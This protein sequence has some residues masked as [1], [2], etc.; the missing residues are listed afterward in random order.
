MRFLNWLTLSLL[1]DS[2]LGLGSPLK[3]TLTYKDLIISEDAS[4]K[5]PVDLKPSEI[6]QD[7]EILKYAFIKAYGGYSYLPE[8]EK[9][10]FLKSLDA[11]TTKTPVKRTDFCNFIGNALWALSDN[12][13][14]AKIGEKQDRRCG[15]ARTYPQAS[16]GKNF[17]QEYYKK[18][19]IPWRW[20]TSQLGGEQVGKL[21]IG[22][23]PFNEDKSWQG[24]SQMLSQLK[25]APVLIIDLRGNS[26]GDDSRG[27]ELAKAL[28]NQ[29][30]KAGA[31]STI[32]RQSADSFVL[33][34]NLFRY[35]KILDRIDDKLSES[36]L[37]E[38]ISGM[39][40]KLELA[41]QKKL[42]S[43]YI[44]DRKTTKNISLKSGSYLGPIYILTDSDC[45][46]S[47][48]S[49]LEYLLM[50]PL[51]KSVGENTGGYVNY[52]EIGRFLLPNS[53]IMVRFATKYFKYADGRS[54]EK[55][56]FAPNIV[57]KKGQDAMRVALEHAR[58]YL[59]SKKHFDTIAK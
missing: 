11:Y 4:L 19:K 21:G 12:H 35:M 46:S 7:I 26:G 54:Y 59:A 16:V 29:E 43:Q 32:E 6:K 22:S 34:L 23:F 24:Y 31:E 56:G 57:L 2:A 33:L 30:F 9:Q 39:Q 48:E 8:G 13:L 15:D 52:G 27:Y 36:Y 25:Q 5:N 37:D 45:A 58:A 40:K 41:E 20:E 3:E 51:A 47:C 38:R 53:R 10:D 55:V 1:M 49:T 14:G 18:T 42:D 28:L 50:H 17:V 44:T